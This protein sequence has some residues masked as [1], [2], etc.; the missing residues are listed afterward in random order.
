ML[1]EKK[2]ELARSCQL[3]LV[4]SGKLAGLIH[5]SM[6]TVVGETRAVNRAYGRGIRPAHAFSSLAMG[7]SF[8]A[9][10]G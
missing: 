4:S 9:K 6:G 5:D 3:A 7:E 2:G 10:G 8:L 1:R